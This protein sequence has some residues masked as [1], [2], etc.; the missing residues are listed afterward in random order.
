MTIRERVLAA[1]ASSGEALS[2]A[3]LA[4]ASQADVANVRVLL[5][6]EVASGRVAR[7]EDAS[8]SGSR[9]RVRYRLAVPPE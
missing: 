6:G 7:L 9:T 8:A 2:A 5:A 4:D 1:L 3:Q